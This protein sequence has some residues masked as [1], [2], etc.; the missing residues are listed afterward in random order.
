MRRA[1]RILRTPITG[2]LDGVGTSASKSVESLAIGSTARASAVW[3]QLTAAGQRA[4]AQPALAEQTSGSEAAAFSLLQHSI[5]SNG[6]TR[7][8][9]LIAVKVGMTQEWDA[10]GVRVPLSVLWVDDCQA[11]SPRG[12]AGCVGRC[13]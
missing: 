13:N 12:C 2:L 6:A 8:S 5:R 3:Q 9:G 10:W 11:S 7:R 1:A 4:Y